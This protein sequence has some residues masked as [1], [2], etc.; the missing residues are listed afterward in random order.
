MVLSGYSGKKMKILCIISG[1]AAFVNSGITG[2]A[3][4]CSHFGFELFGAINGYSPVLSQGEFNLRPINLE[5]GKRVQNQ[6][7]S[8]LGCSKPRPLPSS[9]DDF[10]R[11]AEQIIKEGFDGVVTIGGDSSLEISAEVKKACQRKDKHISV[12]L[13]GKTL[14]DDIA[15]KYDT[16]HTMGNRSS[17]QNLCQQM[18]NISHSSSMAAH[19]RFDLIVLP[20]RESGRNS[21]SCAS[22]VTNLATFI[23]EEFPKGITYEN[24][25]RLL[26]AVVIKSFIS[27]TSPGNGLICVSEGLIE[28]I[29]DKPPLSYDAG[30][31]GTF[32][33]GN[34]GDGHGHVVHADYPFGAITALVLSKRLHD[35]GLN[36]H[37]NEL[38]QGGEF[39]IRSHALGPTAQSVSPV[40]VDSRIGLN[41]GFAAI[42]AIR[43]NK[44]TI[45]ITLN[46]ET[47][48]KTP[49]SDLKKEGQRTQ[50]RGVDLDSDVWR[51]IT[52]R[53]TVLTQDDI[54]SQETLETIQNIFNGLASQEVI[55]KR[56]KEPLALLTRN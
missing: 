44:D 32:P 56:Y 50:T 22:T 45:V 41:C 39:Q 42:E 27:P 38:T 53:R 15:I 21:A 37:L 30:P 28:S 40:F 9:T 18:Q 46:G 8:I 6:P 12:L 35:L 10:D 14:D 55:R 19:N 33:V 47:I 29:V 7:G 24:F 36:K 23:G 4:G 25:I 1:G 51:I 31:F 2:L 20:G 48:V 43:N 3:T 13:I 16:A 5:L 11:I 52:K 49:F 34:T 26:E 17:V 54:S